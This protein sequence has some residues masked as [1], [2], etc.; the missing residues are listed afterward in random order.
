[1]QNDFSLGTGATGKIAAAGTLNQLPKNLR[2]WFTI[3]DAHVK[4]MAETTTTN[5][6]P[7][8]DYGNA[9]N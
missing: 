2:A 1:M 3:L 9:E 4:T 6:G 7:V 5:P 8:V